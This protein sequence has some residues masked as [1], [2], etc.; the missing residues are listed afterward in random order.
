MRS[1]DRAVTRADTLRLRWLTVIIFVMAVLTVGW[2]LINIAVPNRRTLTSGTILTLG[3]S[4]ADLARLTVGP[5]WS[6]VPSQTD[7]RLDYVLRRGHV[8]LAISYVALIDRA[9]TA[10]LW[11]GLRQ[12]MEVSNPGV[13]LGRPSAFKTAQGRR[14][15][16]G[17]LASSTDIGTAAVVGNPSGTFAVEMVLVSPRR[18]S[19]ANLAAARELMRSLR[20][21]VPP[22]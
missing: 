21:V 13:R 19:R 15:A 18:A 6:M 16:Q 5:G 1:G 2:P 8:E 3:P 22:R 9:Q 20:M 11:T 14:G 17:A 12:V 7:P 4:Q 10:H